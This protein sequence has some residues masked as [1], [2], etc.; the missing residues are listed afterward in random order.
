MRWC[1]R[2]FV[3]DM[4]R[5]ERHAH[6]YTEQTRTMKQRIRLVLVIAAAMAAAARP[7]NG[8]SGPQAPAQAGDNAARV[9]ADA[10]A[11]MGG[12]TKL[13]AIKTLVVTGRT[14]QVRGD[15]LVPIEF[16]IQAELPDKFARRDEFP[17]QDAG[18]TVTGFNGD[19]FLQSPAPQPPP[20]R[21]GGPPPPTPQ[22]LEAQA[23]VQLA[24]AKQDFARLML[25]LFAASY[26][27]HPLTF[28]YVGQAE[29]PQG[30]ADVIDV[31]GPG[32]FAAR[33]F[34]DG[35]TRLPIML[36]WQGRQTPARGRGPGGPAA[37]APPAGAPAA[38][39]PA[40]ENRLYFAEYQSFDG[41]RLPTRVR[42]AVAG[43]TTEETTF[44]RFRIN[45]RVDPGRFEPGH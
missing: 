42:R 23:R 19:R 38:P 27:S 3:D 12:E 18:P 39:P 25:G 16:E 26:P 7:T 45:A 35:K 10:R 24:N 32:D 36:S 8:Q 28:A 6:A 11:A 31:K 1:A 34:V 20:A 22:Q 37:G 43:D 5:D 21:P 9:I 15:N 40:V 13:T 2:P 44:D 30:R 14:R 4:S 33:L 29:A 41:L 17:A